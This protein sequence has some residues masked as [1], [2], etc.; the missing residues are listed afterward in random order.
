[1][2]EIAALFTLDYQSLLLG[3]LTILIGFQSVLKVK[4]WYIADTGLRLAQTQTKKQ[5]K[6]VLVC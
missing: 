6:N 1:M 4:D 5:S 2:D 3:F